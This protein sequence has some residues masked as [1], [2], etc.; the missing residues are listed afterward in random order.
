[1][2]DDGACPMDTLKHVFIYAK[3]NKKH[4][5]IFDIKDCKNDMITLMKK[6]PKDVDVRVME[7]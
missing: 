1:M 5:S 3:Q 2:I 6:L 4:F 7:K